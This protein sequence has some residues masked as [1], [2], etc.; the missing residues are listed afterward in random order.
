MPEET[1]PAAAEPTRRR[2]VAA[3]TENAG[4]GA[5][6]IAAILAIAVA[7]LAFALYKRNSSA[8]A[9]SAT[10]AKTMG[11][12]S[13]QVIELRTKLALEHS[14]LE[15]ARS[16]HHAVL[17]R[18]TAEL[19]TTSNRFV[20]TILLLAR[21][22]EETHVA[23]AQIPAKAAALATLEAQH[24]ELQRRAGMIPGLQLEVAEMKEKLQQAQFAHVALQESLSLIRTEKA[25]LERK[26]E[27][28]AF[29]RLQARRADEAAAV[30]RQ[31]AANKRVNVSDRRVRLELQPDGTVRPALTASIP[32]SQ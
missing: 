21:A 1:T 28:P 26:L 6:V 10:D 5:K 9:Q 31:T 2:P 12:L 8:A 3:S 24:D 4:G 32:T 7:G 22:R 29:L 25:N 23:Q 14:N 16:N 18:R 30:Y 13:N 17:D 19:M 27:D 15:V 20:Q 11:S